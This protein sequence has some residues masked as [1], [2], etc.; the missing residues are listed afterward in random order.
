MLLVRVVQ[1][2]EVDT[3]SIMHAS[4]VDTAKQS[5]LVKGHNADIV[6]I[7]RLHVTTLMERGIESRSEEA[8]T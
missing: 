2:Q 6:K 8:P 3:E 7:S 1:G 5:A 4:L